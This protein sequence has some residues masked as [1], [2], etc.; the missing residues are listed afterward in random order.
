LKGQNCSLVRSRSE[1]MALR[2]PL[3]RFY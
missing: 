1:A 2:S 3:L